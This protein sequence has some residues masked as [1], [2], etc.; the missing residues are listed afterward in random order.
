MPPPTSAFAARLALFA[1]QSIEGDVNGVKS[2]FSSWDSCMSK[3]YCKDQG[4]PPFQ[5]SPYQGYHTQPPPFYNSQPQYAH[6]ETG[7]SKVGE[8]SL[9]AMPSWDHA[10]ERRISEHHQSE[11]MELGRI[12]PDQEQKAPMLANQAP[13]PYGG[14]GTHGGYSDT[15]PYQRNIAQEGGDLGGAAHYDQN[16]TYRGAQTMGTIPASGVAVAGAGTGAGAALAGRQTPGSSYNYGNTQPQRPALEPGHSSYSVSSPSTSFAP[17]SQAHELLGIS[18]PP[19][20]QQSGYGV[21]PYQQQGYQSQQSYQPYQ[22]ARKPVDG[23][24]RDV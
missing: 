11:D 24:W 10:S 15:M 1:R 4:P 6:F 14:Q 21:P 17:Q 5:P 20:A 19:P 18:P 22:S 16:T 2:T 23:S 12:D 8:D 3:D 13:A 9:P 7:R